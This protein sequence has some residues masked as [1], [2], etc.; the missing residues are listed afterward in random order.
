MEGKCSAKLVDENGSMSLGKDGHVEAIDKDGNYEKYVPNDD[1]SAT[2]EKGDKNGPQVTGSID[3]EGNVEY[4]TPDG[5]KLK[6]S[7][8]SA[9]TIVDSKGNETSYTKEQIESMVASQNAAVSNV[10]NTLKGGE[11]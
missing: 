1:G 10:E 2:W 4:V 3:S 11:Q 9:L 8:D 7:K 5:S 6:I